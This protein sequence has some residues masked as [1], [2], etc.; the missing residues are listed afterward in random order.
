MKDTL[1][2]VVNVMWLTNL[3]HT[4]YNINLSFPGIPAFWR[5][6]TLLQQP[7]RA[8]LTNHQSHKRQQ[9]V[10]KLV[11]LQWTVSSAQ[12]P[13]NTLFNCAWPILEGSL[14]VH[15]KA[16]PTKLIIMFHVIS[17]WN[18]IGTARFSCCKSTAFLRRMSFGKNR[19]SLGLVIVQRH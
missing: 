15:L 14:S 6:E 3:S 9:A 4:I 2:L 1:T 5:S 10:S 16:K 17:F 13:S 11:P 12:R 19:T 7:R 8:H 18:L